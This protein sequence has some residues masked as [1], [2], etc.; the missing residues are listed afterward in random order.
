MEQNERLAQLKRLA[1]N[2]C[3]DWQEGNVAYYPKELPSFDELV[4]LIGQIEFRERVAFIATPYPRPYFQG[5]FY[6]SDIHSRHGLVA[7]CKPSHTPQGQ[8][9]ADFLVRA[10]NAH[11]PLIDALRATLPAL[12]RLGDFIGNENPA[13]V[14]RVGPFDRCAIITQVRDA[15]EKAK[16]AE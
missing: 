4:A 6:R 5:P 12:I 8:A 10:A 3:H 1:M 14:S 9:N 15:L 16:G 13:E 2:I 7:E 11:Q